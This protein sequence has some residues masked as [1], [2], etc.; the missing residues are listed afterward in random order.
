MVLP[1]E[2]VRR[3]AVCGLLCAVATSLHAGQAPR[4]A[5]PSTLADLSIEELLV[6]EVTTASKSPEKQSD[7]AANVEVLTKD[8]L[9]RFGGTTLKDVLTRVPG[10]AAVSG[11]FTDRSMIGFPGDA[12]QAPTSRHVLLLIN[13][14]PVREVQE[15]GIK[16]A[17]LEAFPIDA[18]DRIEIV[19]GPGSVLY[20]S[21]AFAGVINVI[22][23]KPERNALSV[24]GMA[25]QSAAYGTTA[26]TTFKDE[27]FSILMAGKYLQKAEWQSRYI[28]Q[29]STGIFSTGHTIPS[30]AASTYIDARYK[31]LR[32]MVSADQSTSSYFIP[33]F[34]V[35]GD[36]RWRQFFADAGYI[37]E[38]RNGWTMN[39]N[40]T[41][42]QSLF[43]VT[44]GTFPNIARNS[45][46]LLGEWTSFVKLSQKSKLVVGGTVADTRGKESIIGTPI[47]VSD[48]A[49]WSYGG[50]VQADY[51][52][53]KNVRAI[54][55]FQT[56]KIGL[57][58]VTVVPRAGLIWGPAPRVAVKVLYGEAFR[59]PYINELHIRARVVDRF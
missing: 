4:T 32:V 16:T 31:N 48:G 27:D 19:K 57:S 24:V 21:E 51:Q 23:T 30:Q 20:G 54:G 55:G 49:R 41:Y 44:D 33:P 17:M 46:E 45:R 6:V 11:Y 58:D 18:I 37:L 59:A 50:Y 22:T 35:A 13:G 8:E 38:V 25:G 12:L 7:A 29:N 10:L 40:I 2:S 28:F 34:Q 3:S 47:V 36:A 9:N 15:G 39:F 52:F 26:T 42:N 1:F 5:P 56:N 53:L 14:R 43:D